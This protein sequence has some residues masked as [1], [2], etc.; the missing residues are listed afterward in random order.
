[1]AGAPR[2]TMSRIAAAIFNRGVQVHNARI[3]TFGERVEDTFLLSKPEH[4]PLNGDDRDALAESIRK[5]L[6]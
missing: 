2:T 1:M 5:H 4:Q 3:A 6:A